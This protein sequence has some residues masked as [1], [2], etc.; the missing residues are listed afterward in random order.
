[1]ARPSLHLGDI[2]IAAVLTALENDPSRD[3]LSDREALKASGMFQYLPPA[4]FTLRRSMALTD[5]RDE[6][7]DRLY[8]LAA[9]VYDIERWY[10]IDATYFKAPY[11]R[12]YAWVTETN[13]TVVLK[14]I[15]LAKVY[16]ARGLVTGVPVAWTVCD[17]YT[18]DST[19]FEPLMEQILM[20][21]ASVRRGGVL[22]DAGFSKKTHY[23]LVARAGGRAFLDF[24]WNAK[25]SNGAHPHYDEMYEIWKNNRDEWYTFAGKRS[26]IETTNHAIKTPIKPMLRAQKDVPRE[27][28][29][30]ALL[31][32]YSLTRF[33]ELVL[34][35]KIKLPEFADA[36]CRA[37]MNEA[38]R[39]KRRS[40]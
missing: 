12:K 34:K 13:G 28:E 19:Q 23:E 27:N 7:R 36:A 26:L 31:L 10:V 30:L 22:A 11:F 3:A 1:M 29:V 32:G 18:N 25:P 39:P 15:K 38:I 4:A 8:D 40:A 35:H 17:D 14:K 20:R 24:D 21:G 16:I 2:V 33:P 37:F 5:L 9:C 6:L